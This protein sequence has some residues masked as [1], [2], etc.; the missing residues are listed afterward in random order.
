[1][2]RRNM[3]ANMLRLQAVTVC[4]ISDRKALCQHLLILVCHGKLES[5]RCAVS[6]LLDRL[7]KIAAV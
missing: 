1:M 6:H 5:F 3:H 7:H 2:K 4:A